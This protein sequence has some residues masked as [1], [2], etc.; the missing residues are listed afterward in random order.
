MCA[1]GVAAPAD[2]CLVHSGDPAAAGGRGWSCGGHGGGRG[3][4][5]WGG[6]AAGWREAVP[7]RHTAALLL[8]HAQ[9]K[10]SQ[11]RYLLYLVFPGEIYFWAHIYIYIKLVLFFIWW[12][13]VWGKD[14]PVLWNCIV[15]DSEPQW[16][17]TL[18]DFFLLNTMRTLN[19]YYD[20]SV[21][22]Q[23]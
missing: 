1:E 23:L 20:R 17:G 2:P 14:V 15:V 8:R 6:Q 19:I 16:S 10:L 21:R 18:G 9:R 13:E 7:S 4:P 22:N 11:L 5:G 3:D 12:Q